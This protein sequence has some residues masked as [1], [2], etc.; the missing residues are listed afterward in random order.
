MSSVIY[1]PKQNIAPFNPPVGF[2]LLY[3]K[4]VLGDIRK[5][6][7]SDDWKI[8]LQSNNSPLGLLFLAADPVNF[9]PYYDF[10]E[11]NVIGKALMTNEAEFWNSP[12][13]GIDMLGFKARGSGHRY[14]N[15]EFFSLKDSC[16]FYYRNWEVEN[17]MDVGSWIMSRNSNSLTLNG[18]LP[19]SNG[20]AVRFVR[21]PSPLSEGE[22]GEYIGN[23]GKKYAT[24]CISG[25]EWL[26]ESLA[27]TRFRNG[28]IIPWHGANPA[29]F[30]T[31]SE[32]ANLITPGVCAYNNNL[33]GVYEG[34][35]FP[36]PP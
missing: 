34:F 33:N 15:G 28:D 18:T 10:P 13:V 21:Y 22:S 27:E 36:S 11:V 17:S 3:N 31:N 5:L 30:Y 25:C 6:S 2:G 24:K 1:I 20:I 12:R 19:T 35:T 7:C 23:D 16:W 14:S 32:W 26:V 4:H 9:D 29:S 8:P